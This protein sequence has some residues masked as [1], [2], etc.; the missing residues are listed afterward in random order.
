MKFDESLGREIRDTILHLLRDYSEALALAIIMA[1]ILRTFVFAAYRISNATMEPNLKLGDFVL[2]YKMPYGF[3]IPLTDIHIGQT[4][5]RRG[6]LIIFR[7]PNIVGQNCVK[8]VAGL[9]GDRIEIKKQRLYINGKSAQYSRSDSD[10]S[11]LLSDRD[12]FVVLQ[13]KIGSNKH[14]ILI[15]ASKASGDFGPLIVPPGT[16]FALGDNRDYSEDSRQWGG[17]SFRA[18]ESRVFLVWLSIEW[19]LM[20]DDSYE[21]HIRWNRIFSFVR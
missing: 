9:P 21:S 19:Q 18:I 13:E 14:D 2:G 3:N 1:I 10:Y 7:C 6:E 15:S 8:R 11:S 4:Q 16:F 5:P 20:P 17:V 12:Q